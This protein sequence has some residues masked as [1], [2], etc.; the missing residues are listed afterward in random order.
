M[1]SN[2]DPQEFA[3]FYK[4]YVDKLNSAW[5]ALATHGMSSGQFKEADKRAA[6][7]YKTLQSKRG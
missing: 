4:E 6:E 2:I 7:A 5:E 1:A 3:K